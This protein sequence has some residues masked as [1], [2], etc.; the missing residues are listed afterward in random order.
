MIESGYPE[1]VASSWFG[2]WGPAGVPAERVNILAEAIRRTLENPEIVAGFTAAGTQITY[3]PPTEFKTFIDAEIE[4]YRKVV[5]DSG[6][7]VE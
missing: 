2:I 7:R 5:A 3:L 4:R 6:A 1:F